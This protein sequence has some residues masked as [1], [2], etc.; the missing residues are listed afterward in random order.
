MRGFESHSPRQNIMDKAILKQILL[1]IQADAE[2][3]PYRQ[4][5]NAESYSD[6]AQGY[7]DAMDVVEGII[8]SYI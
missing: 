3:H 7:A 2:K 1:E 6:Y 4:V 8:S 5:G